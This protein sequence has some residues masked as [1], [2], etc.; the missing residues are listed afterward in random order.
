M[1]SFNDSRSQLEQAEKE[2]YFEHELEREL[3][4]DLE[5]A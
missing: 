2:Q 1:L 3:E 4:P 5:Q